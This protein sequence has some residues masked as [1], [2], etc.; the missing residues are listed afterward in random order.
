MALEWFEPDLLNASNPNAC[1]IWMDNYHQ[2]IS[3]LKSNFG[4]HD[5]VRDFNRLT[6]QV[7]G[8]G[9]G[10]LCHIFYS[11]LPDHI[12]D[13]ISHIR[14]PCTLDSFCTLM[15]TIDARYWECKSEISRQTKNSS[16]SSASNSK[17]SASSSDSKGKSSDNRNKCPSSSSSISKSTTSDAPSH[18][19]KDGKLTEEEHQ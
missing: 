7:C 14:K 4:P 3:E 18:L 1:P 17:S 9:D 10:A 5:P 13:E 19:G 2:F 16:A 6:G 15:Q 8:Y 12:K 11:G